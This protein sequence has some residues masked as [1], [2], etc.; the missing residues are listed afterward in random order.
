ME[1][2]ILLHLVGRYLR[3]TL[4][5]C[6]VLHI[7][8]YHFGNITFAFVPSDLIFGSNLDEDLVFRVHATRHVATA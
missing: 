6:A 1:T 7:V 5:V 2:C 4:G 3:R 8:I